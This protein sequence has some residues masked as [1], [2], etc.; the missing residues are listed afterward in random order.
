MAKYQQIFQSIFQNTS[1]AIIL[2]NLDG[3]ILDANQMALKLLDKSLDELRSGDPWRFSD[4]RTPDGKISEEIAGN[5]LR[6]AYRGEV[7]KFKW[8][9]IRED[10]K[11]F[12]TEVVLTAVK[13]EETAKETIMVAQLSDVSSYNKSAKLIK[14]QGRILE[15][16]AISV[17]LPV[18][19]DSV[20]RELEQLIP[21]SIV[22][23]M[24]LNESG[25]AIRLL[26]A[27]SATGEIRK[28][29][30]LIPLGEGNGSCGTS[31]I[32]GK[33]EFVSNTF[34]DDRWK[35]VRDVAIQLGIKSCWSM[36]V[37]GIKGVPIGTVAV[38]QMTAVAPD[39]FQSQALESMSF[40]VGLSM[41]KDH[42]RL[43]MLEFANQ[44]RSIV[45]TLP[46]IVF[47][48]SP[49]GKYLQVHGGEENQR[50]MVLQKEKLLGKNIFEVLPKKEARKVL[51]TIQQTIEKQEAF[52]LEY[53]LQVQAGERFFE[54]RSAP[55]ELP[56]TGPAV[57]WIARDITD[58]KIAEETIQHLAYHDS[59]TDLPNRNLF[60]NTL[61][62][63]LPYA[64]RHNLVG[65]LMFLDID[66]FK[67][68]NDENGHHMADMI[69]KGISSRIKNKIRQEDTIARIGGDEFVIMIAGQSN[70]F[71]HVKKEISKVAD[72]IMDAIKLPFVVNNKDIFVT[73]SLGIALF[74]DEAVDEK[75]LM[76]NADIAMYHAKK[77]GKNQY[78]FY[79]HSDMDGFSD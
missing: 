68:I 17:S 19:L 49:E 37:I 56:E 69:L 27:P 24:K 36:P 73:C 67:N 70:E 22:T 51:A 44:F 52:I 60:L 25:D 50:L 66:N 33:G 41:Q 34:T 21:E 65:A 38:S 32:T 74:P 46:D 64:S 48:L 75:E 35:N 43:K 10:E 6:R 61:K 62:K 1:V 54:G 45:N 79:N 30:E 9:L 13:D 59:L 55:I 47:I 18:I 28:A 3:Q 20:C 26:A 4:I 12:D 72:K 23:I 31:A 15:E 71:N 40:L 7:V 76:K 16:I 5:Y 11:R 2:F 8:T 29:F 42:R 14:V 58:K 53:T 39:L 78:C 57:M 63:N 77:S